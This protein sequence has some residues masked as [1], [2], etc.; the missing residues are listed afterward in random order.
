MTGAMLPDGAD[1]VVPVEDTDAPAGASD[2][3]A[4]VAIFAAVRP[5]DHVR[6]PG[7]DVRAGAHLLGPAAP[8]TRPRSRSSRRPVTRRCRSTVGRGSR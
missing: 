4:A 5:G 6:H 7:S 2:I 8:A 3:P 1:T